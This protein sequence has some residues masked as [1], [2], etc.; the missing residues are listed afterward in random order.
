M[1]VWEMV[2]TGS[3][4]HVT[5]LGRQDLMQRTVS[6]FS[7]W[8]LRGTTAHEADGEAGT[9]APTGAEVQG[10]GAGG[11]PRGICP[12]D[13]SV[14]ERQWSLQ[15]G[16]SVGRLHGPSCK[17]EPDLNARNTLWLPWALADKH[18]SEICQLHE[19]SI[20]IHNCKIES[21]VH[22]PNKYVLSARRQVL[23]TAK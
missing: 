5:S 12:R 1:T 15:P 18:S 16:C 23:G 8:S 7:C 22:L 11:Q 21:Q 13:S 4:T 19:L 6:V 9:A 20:N 10:G 14:R 3:N 17:L 2:C